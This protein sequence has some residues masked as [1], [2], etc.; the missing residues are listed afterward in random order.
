MNTYAHNRKIALDT[1]KTLDP[2][3]IALVAR[4]R[5][6]MLSVYSEE[7][8]EESFQKIHNV[9][10]DFMCQAAEDW[11]DLSVEQAD[12]MFEEILTLLDI[13]HLADAMAYC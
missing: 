7:V 12:D 5:E 4:C 6:Q 1:L 9:K 11:D 3:K 8:A 10:R 13:I 2:S